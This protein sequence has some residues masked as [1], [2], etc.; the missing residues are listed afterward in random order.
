MQQDILFFG[1]FC[2]FI[3]NNE[4]CML[5]SSHKS[6]DHLILT[7]FHLQTNFPPATDDFRKRFWI[8]GEIVRN[9]QF[10]LLPTHFIYFM[11]RRSNAIRYL[12]FTL[13]FTKS[14]QFFI[15]LC[16]L[17][18]TPIFTYWQNYKTVYMPSTVFDFFNL[19]LEILIYFVVNFSHLLNYISILSF[20]SFW[21]YVFSLSDDK[22]IT[23]V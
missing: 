8:K 16:V 21:L 11:F 1:E 22:N 10:P 20:W 3:D 12:F 17:R 6:Y 7:H 2:S 13:M 9:E 15:E 4:F 19:V 23:P 18:G 14:T 5:P